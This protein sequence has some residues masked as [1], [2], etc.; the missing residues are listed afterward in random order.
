MVNNPSLGV[1][2]V[3]A[4]HNAVAREP[5]EFTKEGEQPNVSHRCIVFSHL[6]QAMKMG[7]LEPPDTHFLS[8]A[9]G[10]M[11]LGDYDSAL[12][13]LELISPDY[14]RHFDVLQVR[15][16]IHNRMQDWDRCL[17]ISL[18][19]IEAQPEMPQ[20]WIN[21]GN[22]LFYLE[23]FEEAFNL[24]VPMLKRFPHDE[25]IPYNLACYKCQSGAIQEAREWLEC[26]LKVG[27]S[28]RVKNMAVNDPDLTPLWEHGVKI[29]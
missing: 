26:A 13:E 29:K 19:M 22:A 16:H 6:G 1:G 14:R 28:K 25:A 9:E 3:S 20:G 15:W 7:Q 11:E 24:L 8:G 21:H 5:H 2:P 17:N 27:D 12:A 23:R 4:K 10:W 18:Q